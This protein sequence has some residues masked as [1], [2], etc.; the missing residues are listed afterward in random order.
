[1]IDRSASSMDGQRTLKA[2][3]LRFGWVEARNLNST[4]RLQSNLK[5]NENLMKLLSPMRFAGG[6]VALA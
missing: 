1:M 6:F 2:G 3:V 5:L 4:V